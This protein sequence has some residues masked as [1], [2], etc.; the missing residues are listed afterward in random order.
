MLAKYLI[1]GLLFLVLACGCHGADVTL[2]WD[3]PTNNTDGSVL[4]DLAGYE[5]DVVRLGV[6]AI[7]VSNR[8]QSLA[9]ASAST[10][11][12]TFAATTNKP[13]GLLTE[14]N[15]MTGL[16]SGLYVFR[17]R[18]LVSGGAVSVDSNSC[19]NRVG[20]PSTVPLRVVK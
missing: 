5:L 7:I 19:T 14:T 3:A 12:V 2:A 18:A 20:T 1:S 6:T 16:A 10:G 8:V 13:V 9:I 17:V 4:D 15:K 11:T